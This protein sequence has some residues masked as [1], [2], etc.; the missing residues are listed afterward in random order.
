[1]PAR[2]VDAMI[3]AAGLGTRLGTVTRDLPKALVELGGVPILE[4]VARRLIAAGADRLVINVHHHADAI[5][6]FVEAREGFGIDVRFSREDDAPLE[7]GGGL[8]HAA[9]QF[10]GDRPI[11]LHN[12]DVLCDA[13]LGALL[14]AHEATGALATLAVSRRDTSR[15]LLF[16][17]DGLHGRRNEATGEATAFRPARG[18]LRPFAFAGIHALDPRILERI[19]ERGA[20][21]IMAVY[22][23]LSAE[24]ARIAGH[25]VG[26][27]TWLEIGNPERLEAARRWVEAQAAGD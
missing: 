27:A 3:L 1:V 9:R 26:A 20:F 10:R 21:S 15:T 8:L 23:R 14:A 16:D 24:G 7:T 19:T 17:D 18:A 12:V 6:S 4:H 11:L 22:A 2:S 13:D 5:V 25:D